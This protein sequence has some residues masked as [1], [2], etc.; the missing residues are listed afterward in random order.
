MHMLSFKDG[1]SPFEFIEILQLLTISYAFKG[2]VSLTC[3]VLFSTQPFFT[4]SLKGVLWD[5]EVILFIGLFHKDD[6]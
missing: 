4:Y 6:D 3:S 2:S 1:S 5:A